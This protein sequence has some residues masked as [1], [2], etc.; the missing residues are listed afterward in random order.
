MDLILAVTLLA[1]GAYGYRLAYIAGRDNER[2]RWEIR[3]RW[4]DDVQRRER[5]KAARHDPE[6]VTD[7]RY[8]YRGEVD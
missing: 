1:I 3:S 6:V 5:R 8:P 7:R 2:E 4:A